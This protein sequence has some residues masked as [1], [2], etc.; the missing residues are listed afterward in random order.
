MTADA[1][2]SGYYPHSERLFAIPAALMLWIM[3]VWL[4][5]HRGELDDDPVVFALKDKTSLALAGVVALAFVAA[6]V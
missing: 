2:P 5:S 4:L 1:E 6:V 3:R